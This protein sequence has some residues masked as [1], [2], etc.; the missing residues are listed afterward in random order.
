M[1]KIARIPVSSLPAGIPGLVRWVRMA[2]PRVYR[3]LAAR[4]AANNQLNGMGLVVPGEDPVAAVADSAKPGIA[5]QIITG[6]QDLVKVGIPLY[7][8]QKLFD[9]QIARAKQDLPPL[10][11]TAI[12]DASALRV[13]VDTSTRNT[14]LIIG[15]LAFAGLIGYALLRR[16]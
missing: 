5:Q 15:G 6:L 10:D 12:S 3:G 8:Q 2:H 1:S 9:L 14:G 4:L 7:Q 13:G 16:R 11:T